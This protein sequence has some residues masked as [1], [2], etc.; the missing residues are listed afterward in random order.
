MGI[1]S[2]RFNEREEKILKRLG[3]YYAQDCSKILKKSLLGMYEDLKDRT[4]IKTFETKEKD[5]KVR[6]YTAEEILKTA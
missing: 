5:R 2:V 3:R 4:A 6:F 1:I